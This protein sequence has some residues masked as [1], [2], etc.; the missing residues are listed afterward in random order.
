MRCYFMRGGHIQA[1]EELPGLTDAEAVEK[2]RALYAA[3]QNEFD[4]FEV[5]DRTRVL[6]QYPDPQPAA[7]IPFPKLATS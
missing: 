2:G 1:A 5:W 4:G 6:V 3:R 7:V